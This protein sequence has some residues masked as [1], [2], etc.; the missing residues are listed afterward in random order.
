MTRILTV[1]FVLAALPA[2]LFSQKTGYQI[3]VKIDGFQQKEAYLGYYF[4]DKQYL[5][6]TAYVETDGWF[7]FEGNEKLD[8]GIYLVVLPPDNQFIQ[9][10]VDENNQW[11]SLETKFSD[12]PG[13][14]KITG[15][16]DNEMFYD[17]LNFLTGK[18]P[19]AEEYRKQL[20]EV[21]G[22]EKKKAKVEEKIAALDNEVK[23]YQ[24]NVIATHPKSMTALVIQANLPLDVP[25]FEGE[26]KEKEL[27]GFY[28]MRQH[29]FDH[30]DFTDPT[31]VRTP[32]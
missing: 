11:F 25:T 14:I 15:S 10:L 9:I 27:K 19:K 23:S 31:L 4:G 21:A 1:F 2:L 20:E 22:D 6:D 24:Q 3:K 26:Q 8:G 17:Y 18:R 13:S 7:Y 28:W 30:F 32:F 12:L 29:W 16:E 5:K